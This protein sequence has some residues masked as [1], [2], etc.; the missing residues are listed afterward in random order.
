[1]FY[2]KNN[3]IKNDYLLSLDHINKFNIK[4]IYSLPKLKQIVIKIFLNEFLIINDL[5]STKSAKS[6]RTLFFFIV[7]IFSN[8]FPLI[9]NSKLLKEASTSSY[10]L[11]IEYKN[12]EDINNFLKS[13]Y[14]ENF[15]RISK[16][17]FS[18]HNIVN[19]NHQSIY[20][21]FLPISSLYEIN[22]IFLTYVPGLNTKEFNLNITYVFENHIKMKN[23]ISFIKNFNLF[24]IGC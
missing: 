17:I 2:N 1:M 9:K 24:W 18:S 7:Y 15:S 3:F 4:T 21:M 10:Y 14:I 12:K 13:I 6:L 22:D 23:Q 20:Q 8:L 16:L 19:S 5:N 11:Q